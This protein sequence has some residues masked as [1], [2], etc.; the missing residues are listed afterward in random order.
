MNIIGKMLDNRYEILEKIGNGGMATVYKAKCHVLNRFVAIKILKDEFTTDSEFIK[1]FKTEA[2]S[3]ASLTH[4]NIVSIYDV[5]NEDN[6]YYIVME[7]IQGK[8]LKDIIIEDGILSWKW[9]VNIA[10][11][12]AS[13]LDTAH[14]HNIIHRD[15]KPHNIMITEDGIAKVADFGIAKAVSN[16]TITAFGTTIG[17]VH[18]FSPE[19]A[20]G[21]YTDAKSDIY[22]LGIVM[23]E[24][25]TGRVPFDAD[26]PVS[27]AL[28]QVQEEPEDPMKYNS[29]IPLGVNRIILK[30][31]Q[32]DPNLRYQSAADM[33]TDLKMSLKKPNE[34]FV[35]LATRNENSPTQRVPTIYELEMENSNER[36]APKSDGKEKEEE[37][38]EGLF[39]KIG[40]FFTNHPAL[41]VLVILF[42]CALL[43]IGAIF[44]TIK[45]FNNARPQEVVMPDVS[46]TKSGSERMTK[47]DAT[48]ALTE[49]G[50]T[51]IKYEE[52]YDE[53]IEAGLVIKQ[54]PK[55]QENYKLNVTKEIVLTVSK[56]QKIVT[57]PKKIVGKTI[58]EMRTTLTEL[59]LSFEEVEETN[60]EIEK[61]IIL[62]VEPEEGLE[63]S[64]STKVKLTVSAGSQWKDVPVPNVL[65]KSEEEAR[66]LLAEFKELEVTYTEN[67]DKSDGVVTAQSIQAGKTVKENEKIVITVNKQPRRSNVTVMVNLKS[68]L[69]F[70]KEPVME[71]TVSTQ[72]VSGKVEILVGS[73]TIYSKENSF[74]ETNIS[75]SYTGSGVKDIKVKVDGVTQNIGDKR[76]DFNQGDQVISIP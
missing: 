59:E 52:V 32:K 64:A 39:K 34:D 55:F 7:L 71:N 12:I 53:E 70:E 36:K 56:G 10:T 21:G 33:L 38:K 4:P 66:T 61:G 13:A 15:I 23:Y 65:N 26:T 8:T 6:L 46:G 14:K 60:E 58:E 5:C 40:K 67:P 1:K 17:S 29:E 63:I 28:K 76:V 44:G 3:A 45:V 37:K 25:L 69:K 22:S 72:K 35:V 30:A 47:E 16:S 27:V 11:Q 20:R 43:F 62:S 51:A 48:K 9:S 68:L 18:Y 31:M 42:V 19:H 57:L 49:L 73:E 50:F 2:Q 74:E 54:E 75:A 24:M 41:K